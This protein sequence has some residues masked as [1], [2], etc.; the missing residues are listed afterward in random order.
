MNQ[1][2]A[3]QRTEFQAST[4]ALFSTQLGQASKPDNKESII[5]SLNS[6][7]PAFVFDPTNGLVFETWFARYDDILT[8]EG[9]TKLTEPEI[10]RIILGKL[11]QQCYERFSAQILPQKPAD[12]NK[13]DL[14]ATLTRIFSHNL[15]LTSRRYNFLKIECMND[16]NRTFD[17]YTAKVSRMHQLA[18][19]ST[20]SEEH[21][22]CFIWICGLTKPDYDEI[23]QIALKWLEETPKGT[24]TELHAHVK[25]FVQLQ[26]TSSTIAYGCSKTVGKVQRSSKDKYSKP[27]TKLPKTRQSP[28]SA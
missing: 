9:A 27:A 23:R 2:L 19:T 1:I 4:Q 18:E 28:P 3:Q 21:L 8:Q 16:S 13:V 10:C 6:R 26:S 15:S 12:L 17:D 14:V 24:L 7:I 5:N 25:R 22:K 11:D 20:M